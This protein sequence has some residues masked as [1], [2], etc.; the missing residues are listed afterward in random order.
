MKFIAQ[1][2]FHITFILVL[3]Q[4][5]KVSQNRAYQNAYRSSQYSLYN[6]HNYKKKKKKND[7]FGETEVNAFSIQFLG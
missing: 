2:F 3:Y 4:F 7:F 6:L 5:I 1:L